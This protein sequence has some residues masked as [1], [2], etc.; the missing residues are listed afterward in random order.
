MH[1]IQENALIIKEVLNVALKTQR[2]V[3][4]ALEWPL[5]STETTT[6]QKYIDEGSA[7][8]KIPLFFT[9]LTEGLRP[10]I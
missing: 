2:K 6:I 9:T 4:L 5:T 3:I 1:G 10:N 7:I 8:K